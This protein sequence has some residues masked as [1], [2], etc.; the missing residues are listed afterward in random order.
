MFQNGKSKTYK[1]T[2]GRSLN[3]DND[4]FRPCEEDEDVLRPQVRAKEVP[5]WVF[6]FVE[7]KDE[8]NDSDDDTFEG[9]PNG[10]NLRN[11]EDLEGD[12][13]IDVVLDTMLEEESPKTNGG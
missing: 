12:C 9:E 8:E 7:H 1:H 13:D 10:D 6:D 4:P 11:G 2:D 3:V 5:G